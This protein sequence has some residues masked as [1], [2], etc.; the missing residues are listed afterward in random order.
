M[1][2]ANLSRRQF[3]AG[4]A[5]TGLSLS[6]DN[7]VLGHSKTPV[8]AE[9]LA[10]LAALNSIQ[11]KREKVP[12]EGDLKEAES[13]LQKLFGDQYKS[14]KA[15]FAD[16]LLNAVSTETGDK[17][18]VMLRDS[19]RISAENF[20]L[21]TS[22]AA[23]EKMVDT[24][25]VKFDAIASDV[26]KTAKKG[27][28]SPEQ[29]A[30][31][32][33][34][35]IKLA[36]LGMKWNEY[37]AAVKAVNESKSVAGKAGD[38]SLVE[39]TNEKLK[40][41]TLLKK[42]FDDYVKAEDG[43]SKITFEDT[44][45]DPKKKADF[46]KFN[47]IAGKWQCFKEDKWNIGIYML[48]MGSDKDL[49]SIAQKE[50][51]L[52][53]NKIPLTAENFYDLAESWYAKTK[54]EPDKREKARYG[55]RALHWYDRTLETATGALKAKTKTRIGEL[56]AVAAGGKTIVDLLKL[57][58]LN[59][60]SVKG[61]WKYVGQNLVSPPVAFARIQIPIIPPEEYDL[62]IL[63]AL[64]SGT[65]S[66]NVGLVG[67]NAQFQHGVNDSIAGIDLLDGK[68]ANAN[69]TTYKG[70]IFSDEK[71]RAF[72]Y[73]IRKD[74]VSVSVDEK[75]INAWKGDYKRL[76]LYPDWVIPHKKALFIGAYN[77]E[78]QI[79]QVTLTPISGQ[80][81]KLR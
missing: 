61:D 19:A 38:K 71:V 42:E 11:D 7:L 67:G 79:S 6:L 66:L 29:N 80:M 24:Y 28:K 2:V 45:N 54:N 31:F 46:E 81:Q 58:D 32:A 63:V 25:Q 30:E 48:P 43:L 53:E 72:V 76:T 62:K 15:E 23:L 41:V 51:K 56:G 10:M 64:K 44:V 65:G 37:D 20:K 39:K 14:R 16:V 57:I 21:P 8:S 78:Y 77:A 26:L 47:L 4:S 52:F 73:R 49:A 35:G 34:L 40:E 68:L 5:A 70:K 75:V 36:D 74:G 59:K 55:T 12:A 27:A 22:F 3:L 9:F 13:N 60:D 17:R 18:Y 69:E 33:E 1:G 50:Q